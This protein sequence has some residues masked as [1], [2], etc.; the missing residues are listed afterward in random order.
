MLLLEGSAEIER[1]ALQLAERIE[2]VAD[3]R[4]IKAPASPLSSRAGR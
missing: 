3:P 1:E 4:P 2:Q